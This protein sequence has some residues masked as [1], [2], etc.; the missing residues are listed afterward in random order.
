MKKIFGIG[1]AMVLLFSSLFTFQVFAEDTRDY[2]YFNRGGC[3]LYREYSVDEDGVRSYETAEERIERLERY[4]KLIDEE[5]EKGNLTKEEGKAYK[6]RIE[7]A[8]ENCDGIRYRDTQ[9]FDGLR[10]RDTQ[11]FNNTTYPRNHHRRMRS[12]MCH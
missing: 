12:Q 9:D 11:D 7:S 6:E 8:I 10:L 3:G 4:G 5:V 1:T 2:P